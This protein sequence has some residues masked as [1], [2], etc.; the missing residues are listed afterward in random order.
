MGWTHR[1][2]D[3]PVPRQDRPPEKFYA[4]QIHGDAACPAWDEPDYVDPELRHADLP[5][6][7][8]YHQGN[9]A[10]RSAPAEAER[11]L[12]PGWVAWV[13][14]PRRRAHVPSSPDANAERLTREKETDRLS[15]RQNSFWPG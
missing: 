8:R 12:S 10:K 13:T 7:A 14:Q 1:G 5:L 6:G 11:A 9:G 15:R 3:R 4:E 2:S